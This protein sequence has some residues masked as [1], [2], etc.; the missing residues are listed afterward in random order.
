M[1]SIFAGNLNQPKWGHL[2]RLHEVILSV[3]Q[4][5]TN[6]DRKDTDY[7]NKMTVSLIKSI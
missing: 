1:F 4:I 7:G 5:I 6:G 3:E 2:K